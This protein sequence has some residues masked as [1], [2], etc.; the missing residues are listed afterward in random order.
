MPNIKKRLLNIHPTLQV[1][2][3]VGLY[4]ASVAAT[5]GQQMTQWEINVFTAIY[6]WPR[7]LYPFFFVITQLGSIHVLAIMLIGYLIKR[8]Y[9]IVLRLLMTGTAAYLVS[10][11]AKDIWGRTRPHELLTDVVN[12]DY[13]V[14]GPGFPS[15][16]VALATALALTIGHYLPRKYHW[17]IV[18]WIVGVGLSRIYLGIHAPLDIVGGFAIGWGCYALFR[19]VRIYDTTLGRQR[20]KRAARRTG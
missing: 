15:G 3:A 18:F 20:A 12:L 8:R 7:F 16:H 4:F 5:Q 2:M 13:L 10:G 17:L 19:H 1:F 6:E 14:R 9:H 11:F